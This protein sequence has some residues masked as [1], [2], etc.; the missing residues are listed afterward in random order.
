MAVPVDPNKVIIDALNVDWERKIEGVAAIVPR[1]DEKLAQIDLITS[2]RGRKPPINKLYQAKVQL[3]GL[4]ALAR[5][6]NPVIETDLF[7]YLRLHAVAI[8]E[9]KAR[10]EQVVE[11]LK[12]ERHEP[13]MSPLERLTA[14]F[15]K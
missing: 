5:G 11:M 13:D 8:G 12:S 4:E 10:S 15:R 1:P 9:T 14:R 7:D 6:E 3:A 2:L